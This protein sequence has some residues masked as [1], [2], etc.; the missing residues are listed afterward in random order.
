MRVAR[1]GRASAS[2]QAKRP[3]YNLTSD[4]RLLSSDFPI[5]WID[6]GLGNCS[7]SR[8]ENNS[9][10]VSSPGAVF[11]SDRPNLRCQCSCGHLEA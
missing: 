6:A 10:Y 1:P 3:P 2:R 8:H 5:I 4:L 7:K 11:S 9:N